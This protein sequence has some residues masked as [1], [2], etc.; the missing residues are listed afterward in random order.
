MPSQTGLDADPISH[1]GDGIAAWRETGQVCA[2]RIATVAQLAGAI[3]H[4][5]RNP[6]GVLANVLYR[7]RAA[8]PDGPG[9][10]HAFAQAE[11]AIERIDQVVQILLRFQ[12]L[13]PSAAKRL[14]LRPLLAEALPTMQPA[15][16]E[17]SVYGHPELLRLAL[18]LLARPLGHPQA[19]L[20]R[21]VSVGR[22]WLRLV[23]GPP[24]AASTDEGRD[25]VSLTTCL[26]R[27]LVEASGGSLRD[28]SPQRGLELVLIL[29]RSPKTPAC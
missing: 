24:P 16:Q 1:E 29:P 22:S 7:L 25:S 13:R 10:E 8:D 26:V 17:L 2:I 4:E 3:A 28:A 12:A 21:R 15:A 20:L 11:Q 14:D 23:F 18:R 19:W 27:A 9:R 5:V 6:M